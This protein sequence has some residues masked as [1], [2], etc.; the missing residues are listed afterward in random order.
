MPTRQ[1][2]PVGAQDAGDAGEIA[3]YASPS[4]RRDR[5]R[6]KP[7]IARCPS[8]TPIIDPAQESSAPHSPQPCQPAG[9]VLLTKPSV[10]LV[11]LAGTSLS[12]F[13]SVFRVCIHRLGDTPVD[14]FDLGFAGVRSVSIRGSAP[15]L[16]LVKVPHPTRDP[17]AFEWTH[18]T[19]RQLSTRRHT[20]VVPVIR[21]QEQLPTFLRSIAQHCPYYITP[22]GDFREHCRLLTLLLQTIS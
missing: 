12:H 13:E 5:Q 18:R 20:Q 19:L 4:T 10:L 2:M 9:V 21:E 11:N 7:S 15:S 14:I 1:S 6:A 8:A 16:V 17:R 22:P 3:A